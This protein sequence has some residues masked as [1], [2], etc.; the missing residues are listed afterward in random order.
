[1]SAFLCNSLHATRFFA[2]VCVGLQS[3]KE[4]QAPTGPRGREQRAGLRLAHATDRRVLSAG[5]K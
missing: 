1:M 3:K 4:K 2:R 5:S